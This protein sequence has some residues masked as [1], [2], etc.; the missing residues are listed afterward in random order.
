M[1]VPWHRLLWHA[2]QMSTPSALTH[3]D[4]FTREATHAPPWQYDP[5]AQSRS[6]AQLDRHPSNVAFG[7]YL[8]HPMQESLSPFT[9][10]SLPLVQL[11][12]DWY[13]LVP[14]HAAGVKVAGGDQTPAAAQVRLRALVPAP[15]Q[16]A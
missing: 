2:S 3:G 5:G 11:A 9:A 10:G 12:I 13:P 1:Q 16:S 7:R 6:A 8:P 15:A 4:P 14:V